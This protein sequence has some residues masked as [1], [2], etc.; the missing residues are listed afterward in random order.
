MRSISCIR[1]LFAFLI[2]SALIGCDA[3]FPEQ[4]T[5]GEGPGHRQQALGLSP[6]QELT[7]GQQ[8]YRQVLRENRGKVLPSDD[9]QVRRV[10]AVAVKIVRAAGIEPLQRE[11]NLHIKGYR[12]EWEANVIEDPRVNAF[13]LPGGKIA[14]YSAIL[15]VTQNDD[16]L[17]TVMS[18]EIGHALAH[19]SNERVTREQSGQVNVFLNKAFDRQQ[20]SEADHI[21]IFLMTFAGYNPEEAVRFWGR[22]RQL[23]QGREI[24]EI[25]SDHPSDERRIHDIEHW[26]PRAEAAKRAFDKGN[27]ASIDSP[28]R[29]AVA[30]TRTPIPA[31]HFSGVDLVLQEKK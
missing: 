5:S 7:V 15:R 1:F 17:A 20:E 29:L 23:S 22:M 14:V 30:L 25:L 27:I 13:C 12:F 18:H 9:P 4:A 11:I 28:N 26:V 2:I 10:R 19:H 31:L 24:P 16:Q 21:G 3:G 8:A 6:D